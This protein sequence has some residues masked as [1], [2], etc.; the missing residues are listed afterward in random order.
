MLPTIST[1]LLAAALIPPAQ[2]TD[3]WDWNS[4]L[5][6]E[7]WCPASLLWAQDSAPDSIPAQEL[8]E[9]FAPPPREPWC[10]A[11]SPL[12]SAE[13]CRLFDVL[14][15][16]WISAYLDVPRDSIPISVLESYPLDC[17][18]ICEL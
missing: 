3:E 17:P 15:I 6:A 1:V 4:E 10:E 2:A 14:L 5:Q 8:S 13:E 12:P 11:S 18:S 16:D 7:Q 9:R